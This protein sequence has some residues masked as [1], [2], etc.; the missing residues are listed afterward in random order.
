MKHTLWIVL[1]LLIGIQ[2]Q[3]QQAKDV[4]QFSLRD[5]V[6]YS[7]KYNQTL[8]NA[9]LD[10]EFASKQVKE[11]TSIGL[12][13]IS[14]SGRFTYTPQ[15]PYVGI[16]NPTGLLGPDKFIKFPQGIPYSFGATINASQLLF[17]GSFLMG[18]KAAREFSMLS[19]YN[20][21]KTE[22]E[23]ENDVI[24]AYC[25][26]LITEESMIL[27]DANI[28]TIEKTKNDMEAT[29]KAGFI[30][31]TDFDRINLT[32]S[33]LLILKKQLTD[34]RQ[35]AYYS[36]KMQMGMN[37]K[38]SITLTDSL[39]SL[40]TLA[41]NEP[42]IA[43]QL[44]YSK[45]PEFKMIEQQGKMY[46]L[47]RKRYLYGYGPT[48]S[49]FAQHQEN[50]FSTNFGDLTNTFYPGT[51]VG[52]NLS[53]PIFDG[54]QKSAKTQQA[55]INIQ[56]TENTKNQLENAIEMEVFAARTNYMRAKEQLAL[57][58]ENMKLAEDI[59]KRV[60]I[61]YQ[62]GL[63]SSLDVVSTEK[64]YKEAQKNYLNGIYDLLI[65]RADL[66]KALGQ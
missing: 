24:K 18:L 41:S 13:Q 48:L 20:V 35:L 30:E 52:L 42:E 31:K 59:Y 64:D 37:V 29:N 25:M 11:V 1:A 53:I 55:K 21:K 47:D 60:N 5:A 33:N 17:D 66:K 49:A 54:L 34:A 22:Y 38:D 50:A 9:H 43:A 61:K 23:V 15:I 45:R 16:S 62:N 44:D 2:V 57:Q 58:E 36:L 7:K 28:T 19:R 26:V 56:K 12:P 6:D 3:A 4:K 63:S 32:Y 51:F 27:T 40:H 14:A 46:D 65:A 8:L 39:K 10:E